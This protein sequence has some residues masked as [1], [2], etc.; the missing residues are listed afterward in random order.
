ML[1]N[2][3]HEREQRITLANMFLNG[4]RNAYGNLVE[5]WYEVPGEDRVAILWDSSDKEISEART[6]LMWAIYY[7]LLTHGQEESWCK[8]VAGSMAWEWVEAQGKP[9]L[10]WLQRLS[11]L[12]PDRVNIYEC[13]E[14]IGTDHGYWIEDYR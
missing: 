5:E 12:F 10:L 7:L 9:N 6:S 4:W 11:H 13:K 3:L 1:E 2:W 8:D 14:F